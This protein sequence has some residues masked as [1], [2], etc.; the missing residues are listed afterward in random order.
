MNKKNILL[1]A[2]CLISLTI[3]SQSSIPDNYELKY[4]TD[5]KTA[6]ELKNFEFSDPNVWKLSPDCEATHTL[7]SLEKGTYAPPHRSPHVIALIANMQFSDFVLE[8]NIQQ[9]GREYG[10]RDMCI[11]FNFVDSSN[12]YYVHMASKTDDHAH[13]IFIVYDEPRTKIS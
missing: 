9:T 1:I 13:N 4:R 7:E 10:H 5:F 11:F 2:L 8:A 12:F 6:D 3:F